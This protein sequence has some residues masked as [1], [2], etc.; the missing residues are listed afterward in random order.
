MGLL[1][2]LFARPPRPSRSDLA[3][4]TAYAHL[5]ES[6]GTERLVRGVDESRLPAPKERLREIIARVWLDPRMRAV[7]WC[8]DLR[9]AWGGLHYFFP[10]PELAR[11]E[12]IERI[13]RAEAV[14]EPIPEADRARAE[15]AL[16]L[17]RA[18]HDGLLRAA[19]DLD[20]HAAELRSNRA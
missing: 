18:A 10:R 4:L 20:R 13:A 9:R 3:L 2:R 8:D 15:E 11:I 1:A 7:P 5:L 6:I 19:S 12:A 14:G 17:L 16:A